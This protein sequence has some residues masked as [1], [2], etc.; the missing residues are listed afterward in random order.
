MVINMSTWTILFIKD[1]MEELLTEPLTQ[2]AE[3]SDGISVA[4][5]GA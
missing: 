1:I 4:I 5:M 2:K 3:G